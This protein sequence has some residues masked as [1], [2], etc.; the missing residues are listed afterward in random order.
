MVAPDVNDAGHATGGIQGDVPEPAE[1]SLA[2]PERPPISPAV[3]NRPE[4]AADGTL[5]VHLYW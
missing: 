3:A 4:A 2:N 1:P 5:A